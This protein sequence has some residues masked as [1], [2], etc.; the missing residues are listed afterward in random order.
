MKTKLLA[1]ALL[2]G[3][4]MFAQTRFSIGV[5]IGVYGPG[6]YQPAPPRY[7]GVRPPC[8]GP[9]YSWNDGYWDQ[10]P[11]RGTW[12]NGYWTT[13]SGFR[14]YQVAPDYERRGYD[15]RYSERYNRRG[16]DEGRYEHRRFDHDDHH[17]RQDYRS[18]GDADGNEFRNR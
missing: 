17:D 14:S 16:F 18:G 11:G 3:G 5:H 4:S 2:A 10:G 13:P 9:D 8:P 7:V 15:N 6:Y 12:V 1:L